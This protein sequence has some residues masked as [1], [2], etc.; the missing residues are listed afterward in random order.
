[1]GEQGQEQ[2]D[3]SHARAQ[4]GRGQPHAAAVAD[5]RRLGPRG[6]RPA[7]G[8][9]AELGL[10]KKGGGGPSRKEARKSRTRDCTVAVARPNW[11]AMSAWGRPSTKKAR[12]TS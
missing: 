7:A 4:L 11:A 8:W 12:S 3:A 6:P 5:R 9:P 2:E 1:L 10:E